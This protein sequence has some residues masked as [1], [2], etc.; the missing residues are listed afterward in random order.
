MTVNHSVVYMYYTSSLL[1]LNINPLCKIIVSCYTS[2]S[3]NFLLS[4]TIFIFIII[5]RSSTSKQFIFY[6]YLSREHCAR[7]ISMISL[8]KTFDNL[9]TNL[10]LKLKLSMD[11]WEYAYKLPFQ[12]VVSIYRIFS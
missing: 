10:T 3:I 1:L 12:L 7:N 5:Q 11:Y 2:F 4:A 6:V 8:T 9:P